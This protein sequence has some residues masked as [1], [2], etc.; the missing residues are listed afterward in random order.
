MNKEQFFKYAL[1][2]V[3]QLLEVIS[4]Q[5]HAV[6]R[7]RRRAKGQWV[8][9][10]AEMQDALGMVAYEVLTSP[11]PRPLE[12]LVH[13]LMRIERALVSDVEQQGKKKLVPWVTWTMPVD[14]RD[15]LVNLWLLLGYV[16]SE[17]G[18]W[19]NAR[20]SHDCPLFEGSRF[21]RWRTLVRNLDPA[22]TM[23]ERGYPEALVQLA[24]RLGSDP[25]RKQAPLLWQAV[26]ANT[27]SS[28]GQRLVRLP[29]GITVSSLPTGLVAV[30]ATLDQQATLQQLAPDVYAQWQGL[31]QCRAALGLVLPEVPAS[32][33][34]ETDYPSVA[35]TV[36]EL[37]AWQQ[38]LKA[39]VE[40][41]ATRIE[42][43]SREHARQTLEA[44]LQSLLTPGE[45]N[46][47]GEVDLAK[48]VSAKATANSGKAK[49]AT[50]A[51][52]SANTTGVPR[53]KS[54]TSR[55]R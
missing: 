28:T 24:M 14:A 10:L 27:V 44:K 20:A 54:D 21:S 46:L 1:L 40:M 34:V 42:T 25:G 12:G 8:T 45:L 49:G 13:E 52:A 55:V 31:G 9:Q 41:F 30:K 37:Q 18:A 22:G 7:P 29:V 26:F 23:K 50:K 17:R 38:A 47:L 3:G 2:P 39:E 32:K 15:A 16:P 48:L 33:V 51:R 5:C 36:T 53:A 4:E 35:Q 6:R 43:V 19:L 11:E